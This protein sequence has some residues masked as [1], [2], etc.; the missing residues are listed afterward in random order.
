MYQLSLR[1][2]NMSRRISLFSNDSFPDKNQNIYDPELYDG[3]DSASV[4][5]RTRQAATEDVESIKGLGER[6]FSSVAEGFD[7]FGKLF[8]GERIRDKQ[9]DIRDEL[10]HRTDKTGFYAA[11]HRHRSMNIFFLGFFIA[12]AIMFRV[13]ADSKE[14]PALKKA[15]VAWLSFGTIMLIIIGGALLFKF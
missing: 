11:L 1:R 2:L 6:W 14:S 15:E 4:L 3:T 13:L 9:E 8:K 10:A 7:N 5:N 12:G